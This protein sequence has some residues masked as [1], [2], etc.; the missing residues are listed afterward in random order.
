MAAQVSNGGAEATEGAE[1]CP[2]T[3]VH[4]MRAM[5]AQDA[6]PGSDMGVK[7]A[8]GAATQETA[9]GTNMGAERVEY[10]IAKRLKEKEQEQK[11]EKETEPARKVAVQ[12]TV[13]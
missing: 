9:T 1:L 11:K 3:P 8:M 10:L 13:P 5:G 4:D 12:E 7:S 6:A 2:Q